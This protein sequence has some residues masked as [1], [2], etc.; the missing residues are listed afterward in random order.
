MTVSKKALLSALALALAALLVYQK[1]AAF[2]QIG[3]VLAFSCLFTLLLLPMCSF[4]EKKG[5]SSAAAALCCVLALLAATLLLVSS[6]IPYLVTRT[7]SLIRRLTPTLNNLLRDS[8]DL[9]K[10]FGFTGIREAGFPDAL[11]AAMSRVTASIARSGMAVAAQTGRL[12]FALVISYYCLS[13]RR[14]L[15]SH[16]LLCIPLRLRTSFLCAV[17]GCKNALLSYLSGLIKTSLFVGGAT[18]VG[19]VLLGIPDALLLSLFMG[20]L[21]ILPYIG[22]VLAS[23]PILLSALSQGAVRAFIALLLVVLVQQAEG[24]IVSP[25]FTASSTSIHPLAALLSVFALGSLMGIW[26]VLLA[27]PLVVTVRSVL[28]SMQQAQLP[29]K[30]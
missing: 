27:I 26:G 1:R 6:F 2:F 11:A 15:G 9:L 22:P 18:F 19:L 16:L 13:E 28:W 4:L 21:E 20:V 14:L 3:A 7:V 24:N 10:A 25:Y 30:T 5:L 29:A 23:V 8:G 12:V 17:R